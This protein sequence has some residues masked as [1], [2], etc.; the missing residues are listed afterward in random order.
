ML[1]KELTGVFGGTDEVKVGLE[2][3][4][5]DNKSVEE[6]WKKGSVVSVHVDDVEKYF[7][8]AKGGGGETQTELKRIRRCRPPDIR[9]LAKGVCERVP[10]MAYRPARPPHCHPG[11]GGRVCP[12]SALQALL[13]TA[14]RA[15]DRLGSYPEGMEAA[16]AVAIA[17][18]I[19]CLAVLSSRDGELELLDAFE[20]W[21][22]DLRTR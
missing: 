9:K 1:P 20:S 4:W 5:N 17:E 14:Q 19:S 16:V 8:L 21:Q 13:T 6:P 15:A 10:Y 2:V 18:M 3:W 11:P 12:A 22:D 7:T